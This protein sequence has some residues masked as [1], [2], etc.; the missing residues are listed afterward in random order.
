MSNFLY[1][2]YKQQEGLKLQQLQPTTEETLLRKS[3]F[4]FFKY[5]NRF[6]LFL[7]VA[8]HGCWFLCFHP[9]FGFCSAYARELHSKKK[10]EKEHVYC[11]KK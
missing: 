4:F 3:F 10:N 11:K 2:Q 9:M 7:F 5:Y 1:S 8:R 6:I